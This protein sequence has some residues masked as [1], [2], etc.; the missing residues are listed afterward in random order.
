MLLVAVVGPLEAVGRSWYVAGQLQ[1]VRK[2]GTWYEV[3]TRRPWSSGHE[4]LQSVGTPWWVSSMGGVG[5]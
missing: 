2:L 3:L 1:P 4:P 5:L